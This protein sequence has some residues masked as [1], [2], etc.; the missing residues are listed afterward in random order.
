MC[1]TSSC[2]VR[3]PRD[4]DLAAALT[5]AVC[6]LN[7]S[8]PMAVTTIPEG[9]IPSARDLTSRRAADHRCVGRA[10]LDGVEHLMEV[11]PLGAEDDQQLD[12]PPR[13]CRL[14][15]G[16]PRFRGLGRARL[17]HPDPVAGAGT[18]PDVVVDRVHAGK[19]AVPPAWRGQFD[20]VSPRAE[21]RPETRYLQGVELPAG[22]SSCPGWAWAR[23]RAAE[24]RARRGAGA[25]SP[26]DGLHLASLGAPSHFARS[27]LASKIP[28][29]CSF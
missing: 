10:F 25:A 28:I 18:S 19:A 29:E 23:R 14:G 22:F 6:R 20:R 4:S 7:P 27:T 3:R 15:R 16:T 2:P 9:S 1:V 13:D 5:P 12:F 26:S 17:A 11:G 8:P 24:A 21:S